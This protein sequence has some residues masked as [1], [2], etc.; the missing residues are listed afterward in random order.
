[1]RRLHGIDLDARIETRSAL[2]TREVRR[3]LWAMTSR[4]AIGTGAL[5]YLGPQMFNAFDLF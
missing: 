4:Q 1:M 3:K 5:L 2:A